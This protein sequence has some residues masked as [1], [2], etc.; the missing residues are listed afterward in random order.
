M[1]IINVPTGVGVSPQDG[2]A[3]K[4]DTETRL[5]RDG[6][7]NIFGVDDLA[8]SRPSNRIPKWLDENYPLRTGSSNG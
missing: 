1:S 8:A 5:F 3:L 7:G 4:L 2:T 6:S